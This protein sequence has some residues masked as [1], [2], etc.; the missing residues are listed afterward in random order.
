MSTN[1]NYPVRPSGNGNGKRDDL[2]NRL[3]EKKFVLIG[4][5][6]VLGL[7]ACGII[8]V[9]W[10]EWLYV[11]LSLVAIAGIGIFLLVFKQEPQKTPTPEDREPEAAVDTTPVATNPTPHNCENDLRD[12]EAEIARLKSDC[13]AIKQ[14]VEHKYKSVWVLLQDLHRWAE[15]LPASDG[16]YIT[17][18]QTEISRVLSSY[19]YSFAELSPQNLDYYDYERWDINSPRIIRRAIIT[20]DNK[21][22]VRGMAHI[23]QDYGKNS[24][25]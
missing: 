4:W 16:A 13:E 18:T 9:E 1:I 3:T 14:R 12:K 6:A 2:Q 25:E 19:G 15:N 23:P 5:A 11:T 21:V 24:K 20:G 10:I 7:V 17:A 22:V 8:K